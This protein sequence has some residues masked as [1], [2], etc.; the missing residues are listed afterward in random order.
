[1]AKTGQPRP[2][3]GDCEYPGAS[4]AKTASKQAKETPCLEAQRRVNAEVDSKNLK[5]GNVLA[6]A[7]AAASLQK[8][9]CFCLRIHVSCVDPRKNLVDTRTG[10]GIE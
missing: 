1:M 4:K 10:T 5:A 8:V 6:S 2:N 9:S 3:V 7:G